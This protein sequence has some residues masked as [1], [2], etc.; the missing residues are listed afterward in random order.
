[1]KEKLS[2]AYIHIPFCKTICSYCDFCK[3]FYN[4]SWVKKYLDCLKLEIED[5]YT[6]EPLETIY[7]GGGTPSV[8]PIK[9]IEYLFQ[10]VKLLNTTYVSEFTF[11]CNLND[12]TE[13]LL[14]VLKRNGVNRLSI[15]IQS[16][17]PEKLKYMGR[18]HTFLE[19]QEKIALCRSQGFQNINIDFMYGFAFEDKKIVKEDLKKIISLKP[20]H[21]S[22]YSLMIEEGT[23]LKINRF[24]RATE[25]VDAELYETICK[26]LKKHKFIHYEISNFA[27]LKKES[28]HNLRYW[29]NK[30]YYGFGLSASGYLDKIRYTNTKS[31]TNYIKE[32][33]RKEEEFLSPRDIMDTHVMLGLRLIKGINIKEFEDIYKIKMENA[34]P[35]KP[36][37]KN[38]DL[39]I[40]K[41]NIFINPDKLYIMNEIL[42]KMI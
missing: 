8:L 15:G 28:I 36:L 2:A 33:Y 7:I 31:F 29:Q 20:D 32:N 11:E 1:M 9:Y 38:G 35:I 41:G 13:E 3:F 16:F 6:N 4:E 42:L 27:L 18:F 12:I 21:I 30:E 34:F 39:M 22:T 37:L 14:A 10:I 26:I 24:E 23:L 40:K 19:A 17:H 25:D 5:T